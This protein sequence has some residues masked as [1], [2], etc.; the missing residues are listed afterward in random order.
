M[1]SKETLIIDVLRQ[2]P[3]AREV[4]AAH[5]LGCI[6]CMG[7]AEETLENAAKLHDIDV[8]VLLQELNS[9]AK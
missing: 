5:G 2:C 9:A 8:N 6:G 7:S 3:G 4:F 1:F